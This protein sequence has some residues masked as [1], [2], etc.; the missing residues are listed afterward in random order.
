MNNSQTNSIIN[1]N[2]VGYPTKAIKKKQ[3]KKLYECIIKVTVDTTYAK[4]DSF[5]RSLL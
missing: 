3:V 1:Q 5:L 4:N 2:P